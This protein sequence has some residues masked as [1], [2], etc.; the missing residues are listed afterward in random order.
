MWMAMPLQRRYRVAPQSS[1]SFRSIS[2]KLDQSK[3]ATVRDE[4]ASIAVGRLT[5]KNARFNALEV[6]KL[7]VRKLRVLEAERAA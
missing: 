2:K 6:D 3:Q 1:A 4:A 5:I 7:T